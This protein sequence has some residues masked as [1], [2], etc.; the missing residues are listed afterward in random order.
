MLRC[1]SKTAALCLDETFSNA[2]IERTL[3]VQ[4]REGIVVEERHETWER[5]VG[6]GARNRDE[7]LDCTRANIDIGIIEERRKRPAEL[8]ILLEQYG[9]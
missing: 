6:E 5:T 7:A 9:L 3:A 2:R 1:D 4:E 8:A